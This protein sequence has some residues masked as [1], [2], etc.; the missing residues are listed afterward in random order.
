L[1]Y[2]PRPDEVS[3]VA[4]EPIPIDD[5]AGLSVAGPSP[6]EESQ[7]PAT[8]REQAAEDQD[9]DLEEGLAWERIDDE[10]PFNPLRS[11]PDDDS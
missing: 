10:M 8:I 1:F 11:L 7:R 9:E 2:E 5:E 4:G 6:P 3:W